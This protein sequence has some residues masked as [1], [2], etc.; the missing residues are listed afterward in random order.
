MRDSGRERAENAP[1]ENTGCEGTARADAIGQPPGG[2]L[3]NRVAEKKCAEDEAEAHIADMKFFGELGGGDG[4]ID[5]IEIRDGAEDEEPQ[6]QKPADAGFGW[7]GSHRRSSDWILFTRS[8]VTPQET[9][10]KIAQTGAERRAQARV[11]FRF[12][13]RNGI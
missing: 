12:K 10:I 13:K 4:K 2:R 11:S 1:P 8:K 9:I 6:D 7:R 3:G 5:A